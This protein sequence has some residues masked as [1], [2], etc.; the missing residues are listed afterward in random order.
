M[1]L[2]LRDKR[3]LVAGASR[4]IG[5]AVVQTLL[6]EGAHV[7]AVARGEAGLAALAAETASPNLSTCVADVATASGVETAF[8]A[9]PYDGVVAN[10]GLSL[11]ARHA[12]DM[13]DADFSQS[14]TANLWTSMRVA[15]TAAH[16]LT[17][18][19]RPGRSCSSVPSLVAR[20]G[21]APGYNI[22]K[23]GVIAMGKALARDWASSGIRV[24]TVAP[25]SIRFPGSG[26]DQRAQADPDGI[27]QFLVAREIPGGRFF[28]S[29]D[30]VAKVVA[31][32]LGD[33]AS[34][35]NGATIV[36]DGGQSREF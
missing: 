5:R 2:G 9:G 23:A 28:G 16:R 10:V 19:G 8:H 25:G 29:P 1:E 15:Q 18:A 20:A 14:L 27:A 6:A 3:I 34:W 22:A 26:W 7:L 4:G 33:A 12:R 30:E 32:L 24:N 36:V 13:D 17:Q 21:G 11:F 31:F 35:I